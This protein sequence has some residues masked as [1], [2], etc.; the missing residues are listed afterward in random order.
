MPSFCVTATI[1]SDK[2]ELAYAT[3]YSLNMSGC[4]EINAGSQ[5]Q[6]KVFFNDLSSAEHAK[7]YIKE[8][9]PLTD[10]KIFE[11][12]EQDWNRK[13][14]ESM[15]PA[16][17]AQGFWVSPLWLPPPLKDDDIWIKIEPKMA[18][19]TGHHETTRLAA[20]HII[21]QKKWLPGKSVLD[22]G[23]GSGVLCFVADLC[24]SQK[25]LG[26]EIDKDCLI[27]LAENHE[28]NPPNGNVN[29]LIGTPSALK[30]TCRFDLIVMNM[31]MTES[32]PLLETVSSILAPGGILIRS[33]ILK[34][35][36]DEAINSTCRFPFRL[37]DQS[38]ENEWWCGTFSKSGD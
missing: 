13:W 8:I 10:I 16:K 30:D 14:R 37:I 25:N 18:F 21:S 31:L 23:T 19:G 22:I 35:E 3:W 11:V 24:G 6:V 17:L 9:Q 33:G 1:D 28:Q 32:E 26:V 15:E 36:K 38:T 27:N 12:Q 7:S 4:E 2:L 20:Q 34:D 5:T 29:F